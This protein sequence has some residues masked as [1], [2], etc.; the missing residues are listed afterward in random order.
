MTIQYYTYLHC[1]PYGTPFYVGKG[2]GRRAYN[3]HHRGIHHKNIVSKYGKENIQIFVF[4]CSSEEEALIDEIHHI[5]QLR[6]EVYPLIN[7]CDGGN[8]G[9]VGYKHTENAKQRISSNSSGNQYARG[10]KHT[11][12]SRKRMSESRTG[13]LTPP[14]VR[15]KISDAQKGNQYSLGK[16]HTEEAKLKIGESARARQSTPEAKAAMIARFSGKPLSDEH[17]EK[18]RLAKVGKKLSAAHCEALRKSSEFRR[19]SNKGI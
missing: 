7:L 8:S 16:T 6:T 12:D 1:K 4:D 2:S 19:Q 17:K 18:L 5:R 9:P 15:M 11:E 14:H 10:Y 13:H 3:F